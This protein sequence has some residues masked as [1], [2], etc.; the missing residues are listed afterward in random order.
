[1]TAREARLASWEVRWGKRARSE[2]EERSTRKGIKAAMGHRWITLSSVSAAARTGEQELAYFL[3]REV[4][5]RYDGSYLSAFYGCLAAFLK[6]QGY[7]VVGLGVFAGLRI[8][9]RP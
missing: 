1:M 4:A 3:P 2:T 5:D 7:H 8:V 6:A 9:W